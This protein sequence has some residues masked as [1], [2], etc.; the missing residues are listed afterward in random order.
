MVCWR[1]KIWFDVN[2]T[3]PSMAWMRISTR[4]GVCVFTRTPTTRLAFW[5]FRWSATSDILL[6][7]NMACQIAHVCFR[8]EALGSMGNDAAL[9]CLSEYHPLLFNYFQQLFAQVKG[10]ILIQFSP[11]VTS[12]LGYQ[13]AHRPFPWTSGHVPGMS[14]GSW[15]EHF[16]PVLGAVPKVVPG[17]TD[18][19]TDRHGGAEKDRLQ[20]LES[21]LG[22]PIFILNVYK[23]CF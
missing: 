11:W 8:K 3:V 13:P 19:L 23:F 17:A 1:T 6:V 18:S 16:G 5:S 7:W 12:Y 2:W 20:R 15:S 22:F 9:A 21:E 10:W 4:T 14:C